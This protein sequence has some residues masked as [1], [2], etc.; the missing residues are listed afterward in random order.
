MSIPV[1]VGAYPAAVPSTAAAAGVVAA[2][3]RALARDGSHAQVHGA[4]STATC[5]VVA[6]VDPHRRRTLRRRVT[7][8]SAK[9]AAGA[10]VLELGS[11][12]SPTKPR[13]RPSTR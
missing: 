12:G 8:R 1:V 5:D 9:L 2:G 11:R 3:R 13:G 6:N 10:Y 4:R 7:S